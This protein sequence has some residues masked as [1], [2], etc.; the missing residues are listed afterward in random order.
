MQ[1]HA[2]CAWHAAS[3]AGSE[4][5]PPLPDDEP[6][7]PDAP[8][9]APAPPAPPGP[10]APAPLDA[11]SV[12]PRDVAPPPVVVPLLACVESPQPTATATRTREAKRM[13]SIVPAA[14]TF[15]QTPFTRVVG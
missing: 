13:S 8:P 10:A 7:V 1:S 14:A 2:A 4:I 11:L 5:E 12:V 3:V 6:A 9:A 15:D